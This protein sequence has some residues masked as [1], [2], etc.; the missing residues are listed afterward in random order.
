MAPAGH[1]DQQINAAQSARFVHREPCRRWMS[2]GPW[3]RR[4]EPLDQQTELE[5]S[6]A[7]DPARKRGV[8]QRSPRPQS[9]DSIDVL[10]V[11]VNG[12][13]PL[14]AGDG[15]AWI[16]WTDPQ[17]A[18]KVIGCPVGRPFG[19]LGLGA[20]K[21]PK[22]SRWPHKMTDTA[23]FRPV[24]GGRGRLDGIWDFGTD[25]NI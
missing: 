21:I 25:M 12:R 13:F 3:S 2:S 17:C 15:R 23:S 11:G 8:P 1:R 6:L 16:S 24:R 18:P 19:Q 4:A 14:D 9:A 22:T 7:T 20:P 10:A 5:S